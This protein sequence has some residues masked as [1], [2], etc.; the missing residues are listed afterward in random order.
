MNPV[1]I[2]IIGIA[3]TG[4]LVLGALNYDKLPGVAGGTT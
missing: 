1:P 4:A 3:V 2:G